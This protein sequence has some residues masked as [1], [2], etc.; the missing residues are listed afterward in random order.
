MIKKNLMSESIKLNFIEITQIVQGNALYLVTKYH[1]ITL[2]TGLD[3]CYHDSLLELRLFQSLSD[4]VIM[5]NANGTIKLTK[6][7]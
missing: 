2:K 7:I 3:Y 1:C 5:Q 4:S 6:T